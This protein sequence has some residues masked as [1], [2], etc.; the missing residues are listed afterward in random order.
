MK[1]KN[2]LAKG[3]QVVTFLFAGF[4]NFLLDIAPPG[5]G[6]QSFAVGMSSLLALFVLLFISASTKNH[7]RERMQKIW[8]TASVVFFVIAIGSSLLYQANLNKFT[9]PYPPGSLR[10]EYIAGKVMTPAAEN[11]LREHPGMSPELMVAA[12]G[13]LAYI[14]KVWTSESIRK[15]KTILTTNYI[16]L[17]LSVAIMLFGLTEGVLGSPKPDA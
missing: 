2:I 13:G 4:G 1:T 15:V 9:F 7:P 10:A 12:F 3:I 14:D 17:V 16:I 5:E 6:D 11:Y 8:L